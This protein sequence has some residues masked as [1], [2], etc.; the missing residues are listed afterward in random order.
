[1]KSKVT[2]IENAIA[3]I[4]CDSTVV[5]PGVIGW[6]VAENLLEAL[7][8][9]FERESEPRNLTFHFPTGGGDAYQ[10]LG[11]DQIAQK[12]LLKRIVSGN[13]VNTRHP[14]TGERPRLMQLIQEN[15][16][17]AYSWPIG[18][19]VHW[20]REV[21]R[22]SP[23][24]LTKVGL[25]TYIDPRH[26]GGKFT[27]RATEDLVEVVQFRGEEFLFYPSRKI[28]FALIRASSA[29]IYGNLSFEDEPLISTHIASAL[30]AKACGG[31]VIVQV[32]RIVEPHQ[33]YAYECKIPA[34]LIDHVV[35]VEDVLM[36]T[37]TPFD[38]HYLGKETIAS[39]DLPKPPAGADKIIALRAA[40][41]VK[42]DQLSI[43]GFG[44]SSDIPLV[45]AEQGLLDGENIYNYPFTTEHGPHGGI[46]MSGWQ[47]S[48]NINPDALMDGATQF[49]LINGGLCSFTALSFAQFDS[50]GTVNVSKFGNAN[51]GAGGFIDIAQNA[52]TLVFT[53]TFTTGGLQTRCE[54]GNLVIVK[55]GKV[56]KFCQ[57]AEDITYR[58]REGVKNG[59]TAIII[60]ERAIFQVT[61]E[62]LVLTE[63]APGI[64]VQTQVLDQMDFA[65]VHILDPLPFMDATLFNQ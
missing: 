36:T 46:V 9:R 30:A 34:A 6:T 28:D 2:S 5:V 15:E 38:A 8:K 20:L 39:R 14:E 31:K 60:T 35:V 22:K 62:G 64:D 50:H 23:G 24:Y 59:Q 53:G 16:I 45:M 55:E 56:K 41:E 1:M 10:I 47:F 49:D 4:K 27:E 13:Y 32:K 63:I 17:E 19:G 29:D 57:T 37:D 61:A 42:Q 65:P 25:G 21:A 11:M 52:K 26:R 33:R 54:N 3:Q 44:A 43:F 18:A 48:A 40:K 51:P 12:G 7:R 58:V